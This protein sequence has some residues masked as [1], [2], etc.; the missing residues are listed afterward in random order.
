MKESFQGNLQLRCNLEKKGK[1]CMINKCIQQ[2]L[3]QSVA[4]PWFGPRGCKQVIHL[5]SEIVRFVRYNGA[6]YPGGAS[7][8]CTNDG[9]NKTISGLSSTR[10][11]RLQLKLVHNLRIQLGLCNWKTQVS[12]ISEPMVLSVRHNTLDSRF[13]KSDGDKM[14]RLKIV[15]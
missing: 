4:Y 10:S 1:N 12:L 7:A 15:I 14:P 11:W 5:V 2:Q 9:Q 6:I 8:E 3:S 13:S